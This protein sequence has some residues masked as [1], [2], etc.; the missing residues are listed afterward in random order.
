MIKVRAKIKLYSGIN[1][2]TTPF[3]N[4]YRPLFNV[5]EETKTSGMIALLDREEF[6]PGDEGVVEIKFLNADCIE[7]TQ[8]L[9]YE[10]EEPLGEGV[11]LDVLSP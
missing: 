4:G 2:R 9:F 3:T 8:F 11:V 5:L 7:G 6:H 1:K 10:G